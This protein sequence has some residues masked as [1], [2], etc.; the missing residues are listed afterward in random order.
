MNEVFLENGLFKDYIQITYDALGNPLRKSCGFRCIKT[1]DELMGQPLDELSFGVPL[2]VWASANEQMEVFRIG[3]SIYQESLG[4][5][6]V[7]F[8]GRNEKMHQNSVVL[9]RRWMEAM[10][11]VIHDLNNIVL[12]MYEDVEAEIRLCFSSYITAKSWHELFEKMNALY[13]EVKD[14]AMILFNQ[15]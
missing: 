11:T 6:Q 15:E 1:K 13:I 14:A 4:K 2:V 10:K 9:L 12:E 3:H 7:F 5:F 8:S